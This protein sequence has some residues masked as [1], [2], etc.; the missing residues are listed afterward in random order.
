MFEY[1]AKTR[2]GWHSRV[3]EAVYRFCTGD[4]ARAYK[5]LAEND[6][7]MPDIALEL[8]PTVV[9]WR[10]ELLHDRLR[11]VLVMELLSTEMPYA[12]YPLAL[13]YAWT[14]LL[15]GWKSPSKRTPAGTVPA[16]DKYRLL[17]DAILTLPDI[18]QPKP[19]LPRPSAD[20][21]VDGR[22]LEWKTTA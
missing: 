1:A 18:T 6:L 20:Y 11:R 4:R 7:L 19:R 13:S 2:Y 22:T 3:R 17:H 5:I 21:E 9:T 16:P 15:G 12:E 8:T 14:S 10:G